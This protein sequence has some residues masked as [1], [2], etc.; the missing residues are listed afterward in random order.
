LDV[1]P[2]QILPSLD[3]AQDGAVTLR[4]MTVERLLAAIS[5]DE[6]WV[7]ELPQ[8]TTVWQTLW[9]ARAPP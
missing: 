7:V 2:Q 5:R 4:P 6:R 1:V 9:R 8:A 3:L